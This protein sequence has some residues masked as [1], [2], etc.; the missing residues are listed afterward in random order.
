VNDLH[1]LELLIQSRTALVVIE[2]SE[3]TIEAT[4]KFNN[5]LADDVVCSQYG[6][7]RGGKGSYNNLISDRDFDPISASNTLRDVRCTIARG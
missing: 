1:D 3:G 6:W 7:W 2:T 4:A 5:S